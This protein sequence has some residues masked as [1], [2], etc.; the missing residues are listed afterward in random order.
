MGS[1]LDLPGYLWPGSN[2]PTATT[3]CDIVA[4]ASAINKY[5]V[6]AHDDE[7]HYAMPPGIVHKRM[8]AQRNTRNE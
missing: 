2:A 3:T 8:R 4:W 1:T 7:Y 5:I 6:Y